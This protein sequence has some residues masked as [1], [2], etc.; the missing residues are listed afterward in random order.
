[1]VTEEGVSHDPQQGD[2]VLSTL[3][4]VPCHCSTLAQGLCVAPGEVCVD[5]PADSHGGA[6]R[7][8][9]C[10][11]THVGSWTLKSPQAE[12]SA[13]VEG[14]FGSVGNA[15]NQKEENSCAVVGGCLWRQK[16]YFWA[17]RL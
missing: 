12:A 14:G 16:F 15:L 6:W 2:L 11:V 13:Q 5:H 8:M 7:V 9:L 1:M 10:C 4:D 17:R 3:L